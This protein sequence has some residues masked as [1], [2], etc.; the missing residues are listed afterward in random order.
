M[1]WSYDGERLLLVCGGEKYKSPSEICVVGVAGEYQCWDAEDAMDVIHADWSP[2]EDLVVVTR[3]YRENS[4]VYLSDPEGKNQNYLEEGWAAEW[5]S[6]GNRIA[7]IRY[8]HMNE[9][10]TTNQM[11][12]AII[13]KDGSHMKWIF[14]SDFGMEDHDYL[15]L[16]TC[17][18]FNFSGE[19]HI[20]WS[21][22]GDYLVFTSAYMG[23]SERLYRIDI[24][25]GEIHLLLDNDVFGIHYYDPEWI[26]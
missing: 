6:D 9:E 22:D 23:F 7:Y 5:S 11:G 3:G 13:N 15:L 18:G 25:T 17:S 4:M 10:A 16:D 20:N 26:D 8:Q 1:S 19:C 12:I 14:L 2:V 24:E 21:P